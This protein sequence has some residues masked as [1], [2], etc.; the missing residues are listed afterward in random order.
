MTGADLL[1]LIKKQPIAFACGLVVVASAVAFFLR[2]EAVTEAQNLF[3]EKE[4]EANKTEANARAAT[5]LAEVVAEMQEA[6][7]QFDGR[8]IRASQLANNLQFFYRLESETGVRLVDVRQQ[9]LPAAGGRNAA[10]RGAYVGVPFVVNLQGD[11]AQVHGFL[12]RIEAAPF[13]VRLTQV[14]VTKQAA[15][16]ESPAV[17]AGLNVV[18]NLE[19]LGQP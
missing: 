3:N 7:R 5:G 14:T 12:H 10:Q 11:F 17:P 2:G 1:A 8:L 6:G 9:S 16:G 15:G 19:M 13:F 18:V 4:E